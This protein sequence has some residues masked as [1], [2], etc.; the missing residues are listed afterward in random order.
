[1]NFSRTQKLDVLAL[2]QIAIGQG[3][4]SIFAKSRKRPIGLLMA[5]EFALQTREAVGR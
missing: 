3:C 1:M 5:E 2:A 4:F